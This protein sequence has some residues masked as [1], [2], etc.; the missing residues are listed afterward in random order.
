LGILS[1]FGDGLGILFDQ[2]LGIFGGLSTNA[3]KSISSS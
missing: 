1:G 2:V 3:Y